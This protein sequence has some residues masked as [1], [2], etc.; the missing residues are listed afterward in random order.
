[1]TDPFHLQ[2]FDHDKEI[3]M[4]L[5]PH[6]RVWLTVPGLLLAS[7]LAWH[8]PDTAPSTAVSWLA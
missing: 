8:I 3:P 7:G 2:T 6:F 1:M 5:L 4:P